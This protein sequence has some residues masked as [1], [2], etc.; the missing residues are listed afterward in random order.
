MSSQILAGFYPAKAN[1]CVKCVEVELAIKG[2]VERPVRLF[3]GASMKQKNFAFVFQDQIIIDL[4]GI[5]L[6]TPNSLA[7]SC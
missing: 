1:T 4:A 5:T 7:D 2:L 6:M 3:G